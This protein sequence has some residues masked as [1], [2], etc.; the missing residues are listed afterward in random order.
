MANPKKSRTG[1]SAYLNKLFDD[2]EK[3]IAHYDG[4]LNGIISIENLITN[5]FDKIITL[6]EQ[7]VEGRHYASCLYM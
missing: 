7:I 4:N 2:V 3:K 5:K 6:S 1:L